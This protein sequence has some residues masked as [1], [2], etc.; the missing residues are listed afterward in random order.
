MMTGLG[1]FAPAGAA[2]TAAADPVA[3]V[4]PMIGSGGDGFTVPGA[5]RPF[6]LTQVSPDTVNPLA[7][8][9]YKYEDGAIRGFSLL[10]VNGAGVPM[11]ADLP[12]LP[13]T[14]PVQDPGNPTAFA[15]PFS[16]AT[17]SATAGAYAVTLGNGVTVS[18]GA[19][20][21]GGLERFT[22]PAGVGLTVLADVGRNAAG[23]TT[24]TVRVTGSDQLEGSSLV[25]WRGGD[26]TAWFSARFSRAFSS[27]ATYV[28]S[29]TSS[30][31]AA[32][33]TGAGALLS[34]PAGGP[35]TLAVGVSLVDARG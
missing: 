27:V 10:H 2:P 17:E 4:D 3:Y 25:H 26:Y 1:S 28:G 18:L 21:H 7:Y 35:V 22:P 32:S 33:G 11:G 9:G 5:T 8:T 24:S 15:V 29:A 16:H 20:P 6:G 14:T 31:R 19:T 30:S 23:L 13:V 12:F 34:F